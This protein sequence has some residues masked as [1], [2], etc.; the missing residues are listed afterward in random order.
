MVEE[1]R[2]AIEKKRV[3]SLER[4]KSEFFEEYKHFERICSDIY[5]GKEG[6]TQYINDMKSQYLAGQKYVLSWDED[7]R[8][9]NHLRHIRNKLAHEAEESVPC[10]ERDLYSVRE[11]CRR[12]LEGKDP[13]TRLAREQEKQKR[14][15]ETPKTASRSP[16][17]SAFA[18]A[19]REKPMPAAA[20]PPVFPK[21]PLQNEK[22]V[23]SPET[24]AIGLCAAGI[25]CVA[26]GLVLLA[27]SYF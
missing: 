9:L 3:K 7:F 1:A 4:V 24:I 14:Q 15:R 23:I 17:A 13:M 10:G 25:L 21:S 18:G 22:R 16:G 27:F 2:R 20:V 12:I 6:V 19:A 26:V 8:E 11:F 5:G